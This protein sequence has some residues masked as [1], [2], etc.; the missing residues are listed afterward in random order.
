[1]Y[2]QTSKIDENSR[3]EA[4][5]RSRQTNWAETPLELVPALTLVRERLCNWDKN[6]LEQSRSIE[7]TF[8]GPDG[9]SSEVLCELFGELR[10][11]ESRK[12]IVHLKRNLNK[13]N[14]TR[15]K[16]LISLQPNAVEAIR[17]RKLMQLSAMERSKPISRIFT[18]SEKQ[19]VEE[20][21]HYDFQMLFGRQNFH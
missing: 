6:N 17:L 15:C 18:K 16:Y 2:M 7:K 21:L 14:E 13:S 8:E 9:I 3:I 1:M 10:S 5:I 11:A 20:I 19:R 12:R 4:L